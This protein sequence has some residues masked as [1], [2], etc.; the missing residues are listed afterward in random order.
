M[1][2]NNIIL[3][4]SSILI[5]IIIFTFG[6]SI[7]Q[8]NINQNINT[9]NLGDQNKKVDINKADKAELMSIEGIGEKKAQLII[10]NRPYKS[11]WDLSNINGIS[12]NYVQQIRDK[13]TVS[14]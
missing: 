8:K 9:I 7:S 10:N 11:I 4:I 13:I 12:E 14:Q 5:I 6:F 1:K 2:K 3:I